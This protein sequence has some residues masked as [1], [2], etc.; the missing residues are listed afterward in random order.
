MNTSLFFLCPTDCLESIVNKKYKGKNYFYTSLGNTL[1]LDSTTLESIKRLVCRHN[2]RNIYLVLSE[3]NKMAVDAMEGQTFHKIRGLQNF[4]NSVN[5][6]KKQSKLFWKTS[7]P[8]FSTLSYYLNQKI[9][10]LQLNFSCVLTQSVNLEGKIY[11]KSQNKFVDIY[12]DVVCLREYSL[13]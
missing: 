13:N 1:T 2:I 5:I 3:Q 6:S 8:V 9:R 11:I 4:N 10:Q 12:P 7:D